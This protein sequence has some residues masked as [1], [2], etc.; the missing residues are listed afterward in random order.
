MY[1]E[2]DLLVGRRFMFVRF[3]LEPENVVQC[4]QR[5]GCPAIGGASDLEVRGAIV[6]YV[7]SCDTAK[8]H[9]ATW[10]Q[11]SGVRL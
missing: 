6:V 9:R 11:K 5:R 4:R 2:E 3:E 10:Q 8:K 1:A 7:G